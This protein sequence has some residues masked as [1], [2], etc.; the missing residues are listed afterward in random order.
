MTTICPDLPDLALSIRQPW[1][2]CILSIGK[3]IENR[4]W[5][6]RLRGP[7][8]IHAAK[9]LTADEYEDCLST[10]H[11]ISLTHPFEPGKVFPALK[12]FERGGI[13]G[14]VE[15]VD[16]VGRSDSPWFFGRYGFVLAKPQPVPFIPVKGQLGFFEWRKN[17]VDPVV[18]PPQAQGSLSL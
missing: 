14:T 10:V 15:I 7:I 2:W 1:A 11:Q 6:T 12:E 4:D 17:L 18:P 9:G 16:C 5:K 3:D 13:V 8:C